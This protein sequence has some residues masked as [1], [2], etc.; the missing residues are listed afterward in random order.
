MIWVIGGGIALMMY[1]NKTLFSLVNARHTPAADVLML[2]ITYIGEGV[3]SAIALLMLL[4]LPSFRNW[5]YFTAAVLTNAI[6]PFVIQAIKRSVDA[7]R[8]LKYFNEAPWIHTL[9]HWERLMEHSFPSGHTC[10]AF[11][12]FSFLAVLL[13]PGYRW[14]GILFFVLAMLVGYSRLYLAAHFFAD[15]YAG[16][17]IGTTFTVMVVAVLNHYQGYFF[18]PKH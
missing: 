11:C 9:P 5:W 13:K 1:D 18:K 4:A 15:A 14:I 2:Y 16:S 6:P 7:P 8:P 3:I 10:A 12:L 17:I